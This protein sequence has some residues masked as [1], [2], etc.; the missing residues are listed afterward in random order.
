MTRRHENELQNLDFPLIYIN[1]SDR[2]FD[3][4]IDRSCEYLNYRNS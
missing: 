3:F 4:G 1:V 2:A